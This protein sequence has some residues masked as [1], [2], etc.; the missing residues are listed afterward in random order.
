MYVNFYLSEQ[1]VKSQ[2]SLLHFNQ[3]RPGSGEGT[4]CTVK[5]GLLHNVCQSYGITL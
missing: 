1:D 2:F 3:V 5:K 4:D